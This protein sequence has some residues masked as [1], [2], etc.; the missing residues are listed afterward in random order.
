MKKI[1]YSALL[2]FSVII[3]AQKNTLLQADFWKSKPN[4][5]KVKQEIANGN[6]PSEFNGSTFDAVSLSLTNKAPLETVKFLLE[7]KGNSVDKLT[8]DGRIY[9]HWAAM[10]GNPEIIEYFISKGSDVN[11]L[12]TKGLTPLAFAA[13]F[14]L[15]DPKVYETFF[16]AGVDPKHQY[17]NGA[18]ILLLAIGNDKDGSLQKLFT[19]KGLSI[20]DTDETGATAFDYAASFGN[21]EL[22]KSL[23]NQGVKASDKALINAAQG[24]R[25]V[26]NPLS[27]YQYLIDEIKL[28]PSA[29]NANGA[30]A[31][32]IIAKKNNQKEIIN[33]L[34]SKGVDANKAD[35]EGNNALIIASGGRDLENV[36]AIAAKTKNINA[37]NSNGESALT[38]AIQSGSAAIVNFLISNKADAKIVDAKGNNL[39]YYL[40]Q[41]YR[42][43]PQKGADEFSEKLNILK[44]NNVNV[45]AS[46]KDGNTLLHLAIAKNDLD[47]LKKLSDLKIDVNSANKENMTPLHKAA[48]VAKDDQVLKYLV[49]L[50][51]NKSIK[52]EFDETA[53]DLA[54]ENESLKNNNV[55]I[56][57]LK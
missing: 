20:K 16:K 1:L 14:G 17:K 52:T 19:S 48:L 47:L 25:A 38:Q 33:Y 11:K 12:D 10:A 18:N 9:L 28:N 24:T 49:S 21:L 39:A 46:Q 36:K 7:Q 2:L 13:M 54:S 35:S 37:V 32:Q 51:A 15:N 53:Y 56:D 44:S 29:V 40:I 50:G 57:F 4:V 5:E 3:S 6:N 55:S 22:L 45:T 27:V 8:H 43:G 31:L 42:P 30:N 23:K 26:T 41:S 34:I